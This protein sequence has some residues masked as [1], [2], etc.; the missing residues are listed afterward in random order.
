[1][2][3]V[4]AGSLPGGL[5]LNPAS[6]LLSGTPTANGTLNF[7]AR[8]TDANNCFGEQAYTLVRNRQLL[9]IT[10]ATLNPDPS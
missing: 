9:S 6:G 5:G 10:P 7:T 3:G 1:M 2:W 8:A 4:S